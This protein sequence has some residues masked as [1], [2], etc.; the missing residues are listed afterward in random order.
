[1]P[2]RAASATSA[3]ATRKATRKEGVPASRFGQREV[4]DGKGR[5]LVGAA[6]AGQTL[7]TI[8]FALLHALDNFGQALLPAATLYVHEASFGDLPVLRMLR[9]LL[10]SLL[11]ELCDVDCLP[12]H[13]TS[14]FLRLSA[15][16]RQIAPLSE[17]VRERDLRPLRWRTSFF[18]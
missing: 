18:Y 4:R 12:F 5:I 6:T 14:K 9:Q 15:S 10:R 8:F 16:R 7:Q 1:M 2:S 11:K 17:E 3:S 13:L